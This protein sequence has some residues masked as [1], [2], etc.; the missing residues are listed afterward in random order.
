LH[1]FFAAVIAL[2][3]IVLV[4]GCGGSDSTTDE[5]ASLTKAVF[6]KQGNAICEAGNKEIDADFEKLA[7]EKNLKENQRPPQSVLD[8][9]AETIL[10]PS[11]AKQVEA[12]AALGAPEGE[13]ETIET[14]ISNAEAELAKAEEDPSQLTEDDSELFTEVNAEARAI[15]LTACGEEG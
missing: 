10:L 3:A 4:A 13:E 11:I 8:E 2:A 1:R 9:A 5:T 14:F 12:V 15:G 7:T 6:V